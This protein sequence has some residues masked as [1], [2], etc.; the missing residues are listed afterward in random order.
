M[1]NTATQ[2]VYLAEIKLDNDGYDES[3]DYWGRK[4]EKLFYFE[5]VD[6]MKNPN[7]VARRSQFRAKSKAEAKQVLRDL[8]GKLRFTS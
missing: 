1:T 7:I 5:F 8:H 2:T 4:N 3:G 6:E